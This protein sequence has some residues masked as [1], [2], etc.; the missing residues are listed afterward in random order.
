VRLRS[1]CFTFAACL[2]VVVLYREDRLWQIEKFNPNERIEDRSHDKTITAASSPSSIFLLSTRAGGVGLNLQAADTVILFD[3]D[4]N[5]QM[6]LQAASRCHRLGQTKPVLILRMVSSGP[7]TQGVNLSRDDG[8]EN[9]FT[10]SVEQ[11]LLKRASAKLETEKIVFED[12]DRDDKFA[13]RAARTIS[14][15]ISSSSSADQQSDAGD[16]DSETCTDTGIDEEALWLLLTGSGQAPVQ[17]MTAPSS[18]RAPSPLPLLHDL[19]TDLLRCL[20]DRTSSDPQN[21]AGS[22]SIS[23]VL[24]NFSNGNFTY[25]IAPIIFAAASTRENGSLSAWNDW[26]AGSLSCLLPNSKYVDAPIAF[27][28]DERASR[29]KTQIFRRI[30]AGDTDNNNEEDT[31]K[32]SKRRSKNATVESS[33]HENDSDGD[34]TANS[35]NDDSDCSDEWFHKVKKNNYAN[36]KRA[37]VQN[38]K[39][40]RYEIGLEDKYRRSAGKRKNDDTNPSQ[41]IEIMSHVEKHIDNGSSGVVARKRGRPRKYVYDNDFCVVCGEGD[42]SGGK[43]SSESFHN[44]LILCDSCDGGFH[45]FCIGMQQVPEGNWFCRCC[46][47]IGAIAQSV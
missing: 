10:G 7:P 11:F 41:D 21:A 13:K 43:G 47:S 25:F 14:R 2:R 46:E 3:S 37:R 45:L 34:Y 33:D 20:L 24:T 22:A 40:A 27:S 44:T 12:D 8:R 4:W 16:T 32:R 18:S 28:T 23:P 31:P 42:T 29:S 36:K 5:P 26:L 6:D 39:Y 19:S 30:L 9:L 35:C 38:V 1:I 15:S 17:D